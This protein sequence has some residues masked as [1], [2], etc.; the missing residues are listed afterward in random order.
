MTAVELMAT[1]CTNPLGGESGGHK[2]G[3]GEGRKL[4]WM[5]FTVSDD[6]PFLGREVDEVHNMLLMLIRVVWR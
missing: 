4:C 6:D 1:P 3:G 5:F 2:H